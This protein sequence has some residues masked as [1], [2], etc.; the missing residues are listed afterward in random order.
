[1]KNGLTKALAAVAIAFIGYQAYAVAPVVR[2]I[3][4]I[5]VTDDTNLVVTTPFTFVYPDA[6]NLND[7]VSDDGDL[8]AIIWS[9]KGGFNTNGDSRFRLNGATPL[10]SATSTIAPPAVDQIQL[11]ANI[12]AAGEFNPDAN[13]YTVTVRDIV[14]SPFGG[15]NV[16]PAVAVG[17]IIRTEF[18]TLYASDGTTAS[19]GRN[20]K[21]MTRKAGPGVADSLTYTP[22]PAPVRAS[23][24]SF[25]TSTN[26]WVSSSPIGSITY[27]TVGGLCIT[28]TAAGAN[29]GELVSPYGTA[30]GVQLTANSVYRM[31]ATMTTNQTNAGQVPLW[32]IYLQNFNPA[33]AG[34]DQAY[35]ADYFFLDGTGSANAIKGP[36][37]GLNQFDL[38][39]AP[40]ALSTPQWAGVFGTTYDG[41]RDMRL[42]FRVLDVA[43]AGYGAETDSGQICMT[44]LVV[45]KF[46]TTRMYEVG[47]SQV[48]SLNPV[49]PG[50][51]GVS[52]LDLLHDTFGILDGSGT[53]KDYVTSSA[54]TLK[55]LDPAGWTT[56]LTT[57]T[58]GDSINPPASD[59]T[60]GNGSS[61]IDNYPI[62]WD[63]NSLYQINVSVSAPDA[64]GATNGPDALRI[65]F[66]S[67]TSEILGT[68]FM[69]TGLTRVGMPKFAAPQTYTMFFW[70]HNRTLSAVPETGRLRWTL[71]VM[72]AAAF[73]PVRKTGGI[74]IHSVQVKKVNFYGM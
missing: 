47:N 68:S 63:S 23:T 25:A 74:R 2:A 73:N 17:T 28:S 71:D 12:T 43:G 32:D 10:T 22:Q 3:P 69:T 67:K 29:L 19:V 35:L 42:V 20:L 16:D 44:N 1:M 64:L 59:P 58:P 13:P 62:N 15:P 57:I 65:G 33:G 52:V 70:S 21:L 61:V 51:N 53:T 66:D 4:D 54:L 50:I 56:E 6:I 8:S 60:Y 26:F 55:P 48:Y 38:W 30:G 9:Y 11:A 18:V 46:D 41:K 39:Y 72:N 40:A 49:I 7:Y 14:L 34:G 36:A 37:T 31:R 27:Q 5:I 45:D 24:Y